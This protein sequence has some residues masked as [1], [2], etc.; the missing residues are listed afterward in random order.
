M[1][2]LK[3]VP[4]GTYESLDPTILLGLLLWCGWSRLG[5]LTGHHD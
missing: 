5:V 2:D 3:R 1:T 4:A